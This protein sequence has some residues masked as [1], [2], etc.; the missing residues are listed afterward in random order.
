[1]AGLRATG[2]ATAACGTWP[3]RRATGLPQLAEIVRT[4]LCNYCSQLLST[5]CNTILP[6]LLHVI[7]ICVAGNQS[8]SAVLIGWF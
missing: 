8:S 7:I 4:Q 1:M 2:D 3:W 5:T 6:S